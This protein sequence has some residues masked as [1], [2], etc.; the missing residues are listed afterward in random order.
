[1]ATTPTVLDTGYQAVID[2]IDARLEERHQQATRDGDTTLI[3]EIQAVCRI[4]Y[5]HSLTTASG[6]GSP[7]C[8]CGSPDCSTV[9]YWCR[10]CGW[11]AVSGTP[12]CNDLLVFAAAYSDH[13]GYLA[14]WSPEDES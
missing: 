10:A 8:D 11:T 6:D 7:D 9:Y 5:N 2:F 13:P 3:R 1:M 12:A 14:E 4:L